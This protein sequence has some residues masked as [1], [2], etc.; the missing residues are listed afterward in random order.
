[1][2]RRSIDE[3]LPPQSIEAEQA[4]LGSILIDPGCFGR[5]K[6]IIKADD[7]YREIHRIV[8]DILTK[9]DRDGTALDFVT[10]CTALGE[11]L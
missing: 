1:M 6:D 8:F 4:V 9:L 2:E 7:F 5:V 10:I 3:I 11:N